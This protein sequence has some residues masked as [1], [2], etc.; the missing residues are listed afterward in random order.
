MSCVTAGA[1]IRRL[2]SHAD[3][4]TLRL[5]SWSDFMSSRPPSEVRSGLPFA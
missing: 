2:A 3:L 4:V 5:C 1:I